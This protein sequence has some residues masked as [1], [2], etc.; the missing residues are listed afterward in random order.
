MSE[1]HIACAHLA[2]LVGE[3]EITAFLAKVYADHIVRQKVMGGQV[4]RPDNVIDLVV[5][6]IAKINMKVLHISAV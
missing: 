6:Y 5:S 2:E 4:E 3:H 1:F